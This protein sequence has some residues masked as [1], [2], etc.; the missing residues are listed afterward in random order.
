VPATPTPAPKSNAAP[1]SSHL[2][3]APRL[4]P[5]PRATVTR[6][7]ISLRQHGGGRYH[8]HHGVD[9]MNPEGT[10]VLAAAAGRVIV[11][12]NDLR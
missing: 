6:D 3:L 8:L 4:G 10:P 2:W 1:A 12:G 7:T 9:Y 5:E 11:A